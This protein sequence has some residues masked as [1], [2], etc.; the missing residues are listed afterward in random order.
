MS[1]K[2]EIEMLEKDVSA[3]SIFWETLKEGYKNN[4]INNVITNLRVTIHCKMGMLEMNKN[5]MNKL[6]Q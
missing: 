2:E 3:L 5:R 6:H 4:F 1:I